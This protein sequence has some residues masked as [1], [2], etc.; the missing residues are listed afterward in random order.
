MEKYFDFGNSA[1]TNNVVLV[2]Y[3]NMMYRGIFSAQNKYEKSLKD[4]NTK[5]TED[6]LYLFWKEYIISSLLEFI[7]TFNADKVV[8]CVDSKPSW[9]KKHFSDYK[10]QRKEMLD[11]SR[12]DM[13]KF[14]PIADEFL[15]E[16]K[17]VI[18]NIYILKVDSAEGDDLIAILSRKIFGNDEVTIVSTDGDFKQLLEKKNIK[19]YNPLGKEDAKFVNVD[20][21]QRELR[22]KVI[23][24]DT[25][26]NIP[27]I[28][29]M[30]SEY[31]QTG[32]RRIGVG[33]AVAESIMEHGIDSEYVIDKVI[34]KYP[35][36]KREEITKQ[37]KENINRNATLIDLSN[38]PVEL[39]SNIVDAYNNYQIS[40]FNTK[41]FIE[42]LTK[43]G[44][45]KVYFD[46]I[47][48][49]TNYFS[50]LS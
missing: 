45:Y 33:P 1:K 42:F 21:P 22:I 4:M 24:G 36:I 12:V 49:V 27:N 17:T 50:K 39:V 40:S 19:L 20:N 30:S 35:T 3:H 31:K 7:K 8:V 2:D 29:V 5:T 43:H 11:A 47:R 25:S 13:E 9:R 48:N 18:P 46:N 32:D 37:V 26:D 44:L 16:L 10:A 6:D 14:Y 23:C 15:E 41:T 28:L 34:K 38:I